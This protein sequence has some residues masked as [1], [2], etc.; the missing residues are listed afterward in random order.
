MA[1]LELHGF[2]APLEECF[3]SP[4]PDR[5]NLRWNVVSSDRLIKKNSVEAYTLSSF[6][7]IPSRQPIC[8]NRHCENHS[9]CHFNVFSS[10][11]A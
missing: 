5:P 11:A 6:R 9:F 8:S 2:N 10:F 7:P 1:I 4:S 3:Q